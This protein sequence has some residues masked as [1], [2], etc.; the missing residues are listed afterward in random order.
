MT[1]REAIRVGQERL[2]IAQIETSELHATLLL[3]HLMEQPHL[4]LWLR[5]SEELSPALANKFLDVIQRR[6]R[7]EPLQHITG[8][9]AFLDM[10]IHVNQDVLVPRPE[11]EI[12]AQ[13]AIEFLNQRPTPRKALDWGTGSGCLALA[14]ARHVEDC[15]VTAIDASPDALRVARANATAFRLADRI[16]FL[17]GR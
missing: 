10:E 12:L 9:T 3:A 17:Q 15:E 4:E 16:R 13:K 6:S 5:Q 1:V 11:T 8:W 14:L 2:S 7:R